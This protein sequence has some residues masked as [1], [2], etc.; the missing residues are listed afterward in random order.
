MSGRDG[1]DFGG[2]RPSQSDFVNAASQNVSTL[3]YR[4]G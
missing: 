1:Q 2:T 4:D 3:S